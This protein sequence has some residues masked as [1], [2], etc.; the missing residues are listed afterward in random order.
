ME[1]DQGQNW[2]CSAKKK[3]K[4]KKKNIYTTSNLTYL[5]HRLHPQ[6]YSE[7]NKLFSADRPF[8]PGHSHEY[9]QSNNCD[10]D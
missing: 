4:K 1:V 6:Y 5:Y 7:I 10:E 2:S 8:R 9:A 3:K